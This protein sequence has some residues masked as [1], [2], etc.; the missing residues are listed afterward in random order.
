ML[1]VIIDWLEFTVLDAQLPSV[2]DTIGLELGE[3]IQK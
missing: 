1:S 3:I 2:L